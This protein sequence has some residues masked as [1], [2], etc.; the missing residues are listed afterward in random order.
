MK[1]LISQNQLADWHVSDETYAQDM[2]DK[3]NDYYDCLIECEYEQASCK[4]IC[5][6]I[7]V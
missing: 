3:I 5:K 1:N 6:E 7:L 4:R 2:D